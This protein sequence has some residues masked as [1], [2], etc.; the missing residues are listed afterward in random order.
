MKRVV[1]TI[2]LLMALV[3]MLGVLPAGCKLKQDT[4]KESSIKEKQAEQTS[5]P[6]ESQSPEKVTLKL[7][8]PA[9]GLS[10]T[11]GIQDDPVSKEIERVTGVT[12]DLDAHPDD[13][14]MNMMLA[15]GDLPDLLLVCLTG[16]QLAQAIVK[17]MIEADLL[18]PMDSLIENYGPN[19]ILNGSKMMKFCRKYFSNDTGKQYVLQ[20]YM[21]PPPLK[22]YDTGIGPLIRW[23]YYAEMGYPQ[24][25]S[26]DDWLNVVVE[27]LKNHPT[28]DDGKPRYG[29]SLFFEWGWYAAFMHT[30]DICK[31]LEGESV[32]TGRGGFIEFDIMKETIRSE[33][34][35]EDSALWTAAEFYYKANKMK[36]LAPDS[37]TNKW[38]NI[39]EKAG[40]DR[41]L[42]SMWN[43]A[44]GEINSKLIPEGKGYQIIPM[45]SKG[46]VQGTSTPL[47]AA[48][49]LWTIPKNC[50]IHEV[51]IRFIDYIYSIDGA[52]TIHSGIKGIHYVEKDGNPQIPEEISEKAKSDGNWGITTGVGK[53]GNFA[54]LGGSFP[55]PKYNDKI[56]VWSNPL[57]Y[58]KVP[59]KTPFD[60]AYCE[61][62][63]ILDMSE[64]YAYLEKCE[65]DGTIS[66]VMDIPTEE[67]KAIGQK[68][69]DYLGVELPKLLIS[70]NDNE[71]LAG[72][73]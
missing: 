40:A 71:F 64:K 51:A 8:G 10:L 57:N 9:T 56:A 26:G 44:Y 7:Y 55:N 21:S 54:G 18:L 45:N 41:I 12:I 19:I 20:G 31:A 16:S 30:G 34:L 70:K 17:T 1:K 65:F 73:Y 52:R 61:H 22:G 66:S 25:K 63:G 5:S 24:I 60:E 35:S 3:M 39:I 14:K 6:S 48:H 2:G 27:M 42:S 49:R 29:F 47:G 72:K 46:F 13:A 59:E 43:W 33:I 38:D 50:R 69:N 32:T 67:I 15:S 4:E 28:T 37:F 53:Y 58:K 23:D 62:Y 11:D 68:V 36:L